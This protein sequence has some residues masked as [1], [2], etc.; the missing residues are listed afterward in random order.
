MR[1]T[2]TAVALLSVFVVLVAFRA[3]GWAAFLLT[4]VL[5]KSLVV[6]GLMIM[7]RAGLVSFG[8]AMFFAL[9]SYSATVLG[10][11]LGLTDFFLLTLIGAA[12]AGLCAF[13]L[14]FLLARYRGIFFANLNLA[15]SMLLYG[16]LVRSPIFGGTDGLHT[17][18]ASFVGFTTGGPMRVTALL[19]ATAAVVMPVM[20]VL[21]RFLDSTLGRM[22]TAIQDNEI[23]VEYL[24]YPVRR[25]VHALVV[26]AGA[27]AGAGGAMVALAVG[28]ID[29]D[30]TFWTS[31]G[32]F[33]FVTI[34]AGPG[35]VLAAIL[36]TFVFEIIRSY[37]NEFAPH[38]WQLILGGSL[39]LTMLFLPNG[40]W[41]M[42]AWFR[43][44]GARHA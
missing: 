27:L 35:H 28:H 6:V 1:A 12:I 7:W 29:P 4:T 41:S 37:A 31:S 24:G 13:V 11:Q 44:G 39:L 38:L 33:L 10:I 40:L 5:A 36:G 15:F 42:H 2:L 30:L 25:A 34:L 9:G 17:L 18:P 19:L 3:P 20:I 16:Y 26:I 8:H 32:E 22:T 43:R 23:R 21:H 14:G